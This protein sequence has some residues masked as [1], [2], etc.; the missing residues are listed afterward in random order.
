MGAPAARRR[1]I[2][3][4]EGALTGPI[5]GARVEPTRLAHDYA[6]AHLPDSG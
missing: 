1:S 4:G 5:L 3:L 6:A 2:A